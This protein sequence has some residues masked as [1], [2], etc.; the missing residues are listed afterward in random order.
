MSTCLG[1]TIFCSTFT[2]ALIGVAVL[3]AGIVT[4]CGA[5][6]SCNGSVLCRT[7][8]NGQVW[9][10]GTNT[11]TQHTPN[12]YFWC[13]LDTYTQE[14]YSSHCNSKKHNVMQGW[15]TS[16]IIA[17][18]ILTFL[19]TV[20]VFV[21]PIFKHATITSSRPGYVTQSA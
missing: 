14:P 5:P 17:G 20:G 13:K 6:L 1:R 2:A 8:G 12:T 10:N 9:Y 4:Y 18:G 16:L 21:A 7:D 19:G 11:T 3:L 15:G